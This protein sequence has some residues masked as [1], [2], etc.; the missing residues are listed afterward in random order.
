MAD[1]DLYHSTYRHFATTALA[2]VRRETYDEDIGQNSWLSAA[3]LR[4]FIEWMDVTSES[5]FLDIAIGSGG[6]A[7]YVVKQTGCHLTGIDVTG[8]G[9]ANA[10]ALAA[11]LGMAARTRFIKAD[12]NQP[13]PLGAGEFDALLCVDAINHLQDRQ[14]VLQDWLRVLRP[15]ASLTFTDPVVVTGQVSNSELARRA[16]IGFFLFVA[17]GFTEKLLKEVGFRLIHVSDASEAAA[18]VSQRWHDARARLRDEIVAIEGE[19]RFDGLQDF[20][21]IVHDLSASRRLSRLVYH[22]VKPG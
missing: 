15:G 2:T 5:R 21:Q 11:S 18:D 19:E 22:A 17:P 16:S 8:E 12:A 10:Q 14:A 13:L 1:V 7:C 3:E 6:P 9:V 20:L 4:G